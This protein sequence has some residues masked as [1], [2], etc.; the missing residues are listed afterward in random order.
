MTLSFFALESL[1]L[2]RRLYCMPRLKGD[3]NE[4]YYSIT[5]R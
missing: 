1:Y 2:M 4:M 3:E 5:K